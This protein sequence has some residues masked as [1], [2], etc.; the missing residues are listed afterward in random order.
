VHRVRLPMGTSSIIQKCV[1]I[2]F[3]NFCICHSPTLMCGRVQVLS[4]KCVIINFFAFVIAQ[5][6]CVVAV[7][8]QIF[9]IN[10]ETNSIIQILEPTKNFYR[11]NMWA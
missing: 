2:A 3:S 7:T 11:I 1:I 10:K 5:L 8:S 4:Y 6:L 9:Q